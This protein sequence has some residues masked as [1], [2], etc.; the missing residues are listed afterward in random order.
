M[1]HECNH[2]VPYW[3]IAVCV[4]AYLFVTVLFQ[5]CRIFDLEQR[6]TAFE[7]IRIKA[8]AEPEGVSP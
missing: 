6:V 1:T 2:W 4:T 3:G 5:G 7:T 8:I